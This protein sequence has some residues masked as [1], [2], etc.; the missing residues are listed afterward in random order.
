[1]NQTQVQYTV[2]TVLPERVANVFRTIAENIGRTHRTLGKIID[3]Y[4]QDLPHGCHMQ[5]YGEFVDLYKQTTGELVSV[6]TIRSWRRAAVIYTKH[7]LMEYG[8]LS[9]SQLIESIKLSEI[10][11]ELLPDITPQDI[12]NWCMDT[13]TNTVPAMQ[14]HW[15]P[16]TGT[17]EYIDPPALS[18]IIR[19]F[20]KLFSR[21]NPHRARIE[22]IIAELRGYLNQESES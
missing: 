22:E 2:R 1:M 17:P 20:G 7:D 13:L 6:P 3:T 12:C 21:D 4:M 14:A 15:L 11:R 9:D 16:L 10:N 18:G 19:L 8:S 5:A